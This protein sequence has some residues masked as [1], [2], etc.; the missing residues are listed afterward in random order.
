MVG[1]KFP[2]LAGIKLSCYLFSQKGKKRPNYLNLTILSEHKKVLHSSRWG[3][4]SLSAA[5][6]REVAY[7]LDE[8]PAHH[9]A[10]TQRQ[11]TIP[12][13]TFGNFTVTKAGVPRD[14]P[15]G[16]RENIQTPHRK[17]LA[18]KAAL[19]LANI[20]NNLI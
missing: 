2:S 12:T 13:H 4:W 10:N 16:H 8:T 18:P 1:P 9:R 20:R 6:G 15:H 11:T 3:C 19:L 17:S 5:F 7:A 14:S